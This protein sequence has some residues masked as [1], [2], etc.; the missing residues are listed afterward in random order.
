[1]TKHHSKG[2]G[3]LFPD[4]PASYSRK[5]FDGNKILGRQDMDIGKS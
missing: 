5:K 1:M 4:D 3:C 2:P